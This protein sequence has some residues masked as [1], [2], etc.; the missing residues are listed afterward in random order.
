MSPRFTLY[1]KQALK[2]GDNGSCPFC[3]RVY[4]TVLQKTSKD[5]IKTIPVDF[6]NKTEEFLKL[7]PGEYQQ[8][9]QQL[10]APY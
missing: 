3:M 5:N 9:D 2:G 7:N 10:Y 4:M 8:F 6:E 1:V